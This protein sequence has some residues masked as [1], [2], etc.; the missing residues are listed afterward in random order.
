MTVTPGIA[1]TDSRRKQSYRPP[2]V[3]CERC[4]EPISGPLY[5]AG[6]PGQRPVILCDSCAESHWPSGWRKYRDCRWCGRRRYYSGGEHW[7]HT[8]CTERCSLDAR[9]QRRR[10][11]IRKRVCVT[12]GRRF[13]LKRAD[14]LHC[15]SACRQKA[16]RERNADAPA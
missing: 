14:A 7:P 9:N 1:V 15:S 5:A 10:Q 3:T 6:L 8:Y 16:Y 12:C 4:K 2:S 13:V 11:P